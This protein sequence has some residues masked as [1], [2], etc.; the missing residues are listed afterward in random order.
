MGDG[1]GIG[2]GDA[3]ELD[4][5]VA[6]GEAAEVGFGLAE[7]DAVGVGGEGAGG[8]LDG[9]AVVGDGRHE[10]VDHG[11]GDLGAGGG[12]SQ[13]RVHRRQSAGDGVGFAGLDGD[14][15]GDVA[16]RQ[17]DRDV[18]GLAGGEL[19]AG[20]WLVA[21]PGASTWTVYLPGGEVGEGVLALGVGG[22]LLR[23]RRWRRCGR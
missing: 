14:L 19:D 15:L 16:E 11:L 21:K 12:L 18:S 5:V 23:R 20:V 8:H 17:R 10:V 7:T 13:Q 1:V 4:V 3:V 22:H 2:P 6:V 9:F